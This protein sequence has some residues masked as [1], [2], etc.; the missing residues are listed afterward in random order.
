MGSHCLSGAELQ[1]CGCTDGCNTVSV[2]KATELDSQKHSTGYHVVLM[3]PQRKK[4]EKEP[5]SL[6]RLWL[7]LG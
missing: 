3:V 7:P 1:F 6:M 5:K 2:L 4:A